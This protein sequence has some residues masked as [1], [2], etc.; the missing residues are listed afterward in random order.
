MRFHKLV[1]DQVVVADGSK[2]R[3]NLT[4]GGL[5]NHNEAFE[6]SIDRSNKNCH[7]GQL[8][9]CTAETAC[10]TADYDGKDTEMMWKERMNDSAVVLFD[11]DF[12]EIGHLRYE[13]ELGNVN[14][15]YSNGGVEFR[16]LPNFKELT[17]LKE[18]MGKDMV[19]CAYHDIEWGKSSGAD[20]FVVSARADKI[21]W[22]QRYLV[23]K[24]F[25]RINEDGQAR[26]TDFG[27]KTLEKWGSQL[28][29]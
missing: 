26:I 16:P 3:I 11:G 23:A 15:N 7:V 20:H 5:G 9:F 18:L 28:G 19:G 17:L 14:G 13:V 4:I 27:K 2:H 12:C 6:V 21:K 8:A 1:K 25:V 10:L 22:F 29:K 24:D